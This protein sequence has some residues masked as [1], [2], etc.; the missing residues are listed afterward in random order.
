LIARRYAVA[1]H[2]FK[3]ALDPSALVLDAFAEC[4]E[5]GEW[6]RARTISFAAASR[7]A[8]MDMASKGDRRGGASSVPGS[9]MRRDA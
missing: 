4:I 9:L 1:N 8:S 7:Y 2:T 6:S 5:I 3:G